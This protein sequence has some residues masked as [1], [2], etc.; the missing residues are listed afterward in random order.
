M[1]ALNE[2]LLSGNRCFGCGPDNPSGL[3]IRI[4]RD[5]ER[6]DRL[7]GTYAPRPEHIGFPEIVHGGAQF[8]A[9]DCM[10]GWTMLILRAPPRS[11]P[12]TTSASMRFL[13]P[14][15]LG[16][17]LA[18]SAA[19]VRELGPSREPLGIRAEIRSAGGELLSEAMFDYVALPIE[20]FMKVVGVDA[21]PEHYRRHFGDI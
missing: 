11:M 20:K 13:K 10:A 12:L 5:G 9:L 17:P 2:E 14:A 3:Q 7:V 8:T 6:T 21:I 18:L 19:V 1:R 15:V 4:Y 16:E